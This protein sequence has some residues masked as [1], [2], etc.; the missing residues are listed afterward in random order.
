[1]VLV[2]V[3]HIPFAIPPSSSFLLSPPH[4]EKKKKKTSSLALFFLPPSSS[5]LV[6]SEFLPWDQRKNAVEREGGRSKPRGETARK[7]RGGEMVAVEVGTGQTAAKTKSLVVR[8][9][10]G[11]ER[12]GQCSGVVLVY[13]KSKMSSCWKCRLLQAFSCGNRNR[14]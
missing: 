7:K 12:K 1:M 10:R 5:V 9:W 14:N 2:Q 4:L 3:H 8:W 11:R 6:E 13:G